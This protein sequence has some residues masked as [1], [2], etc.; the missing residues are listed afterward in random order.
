M[1]K[2][3]YQLVPAS[4]TKES[5]VRHAWLKGGWVLSILTVII[6][7]PVMADTA[8]FGT[9]SLAPGFDT[10]TASLS[11]YTGGSYSLSAISNRDV[12]N[13]AC[14]GFA[15]P[16]PDHIVVLQ[17]DF[18]NLKIAVN[19]RGSDTTLLIQ[20]P[21]GK[22]YC[23]DDSGKRKDASIAVSKLKAGTYKVWVG[24]FNPGIKVNYTLSVQP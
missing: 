18:S 24:S 20:A 13:K 19:S 4:L 12:N 17:K 3:Q 15:D 11:G 6:T 9:I 14:I 1:D 22:I 23:G 10:V 21:D 7:N 8:N 2:H 5:Q 16:T